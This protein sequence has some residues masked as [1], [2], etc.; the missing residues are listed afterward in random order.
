MADPDQPTLKGVEY[1]RNGSGELK[2]MGL[3]GHGNTPVVLDNGTNMVSALP[4]SE[5]HSTGVDL[6]SQTAS[7]SMMSGFKNIAEPNIQFT[8]FGNRITPLMNECTFV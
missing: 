8:T 5:L 1:W 7:G 3:E 4:T 6:G 2:V